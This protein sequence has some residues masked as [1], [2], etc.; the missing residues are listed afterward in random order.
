MILDELQQTLVL[1]LS[2]TPLEH[3]LTRQLVGT[4][5]AHPAPHAVGGVSGDH[6]MREPRLREEHCHSGP[7]EGWLVKG[8]AVSIHGAG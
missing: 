3:A 5:L 7:A 4:G 2:P 1:L 8:H 6:C